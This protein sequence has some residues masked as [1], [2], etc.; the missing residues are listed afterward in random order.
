MF[1]IV[2]YQDFLSHDLQS[3]AVP[4]FPTEHTHTTQSAL[5]A[6]SPLVQTHSHPVTIIPSYVCLYCILI[7]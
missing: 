5:S 2:S 6:H 7:V 3:N 4:A 1:Y